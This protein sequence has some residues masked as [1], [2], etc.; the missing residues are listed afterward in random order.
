[1]GKILS[2][3]FVWHM[4]QPLYKDHLTGEYLMPWV[5]LHALKDYLD[6]VLILKNYPRIR[7][8]FNLVPSLIDQLEDYGF[9]NAHD[10]HSLLMTKHASEFSEED[11][12]FILERFFDANYNNMIAANGY[13]HSLYLKAKAL[14]ASSNIHYFSNKEY[15]DIIMWFNLVWFDPM[16]IEEIPELQSFYQQ[17]R[18]FSFE[19]K[20]KLLEIQR[21]I[22]RKILPTYKEYQD[23]GQIEITTTPY[24]HPIMPLL[25]DTNCAKVARPNM[26]LPKERFCHPED[27]KEQLFKAV[28]KYRKVF[29][30]TP[31]GLWPSE[32]SVS[33]E[34]IKY[35]V[36]AGIKW[37]ISDEGV[38][39]ATLGTDFP[40]N[41]YGNLEN[42]KTL[43]QPYKVCIDDK[44]IDMVF[45]NIVYSDLIGFQ[46]GKM[47]P[48]QAAWELYDR[49]KD[50]QQ[51][52][53]NSTDNHLVT[54]ALDGENCWEYY[55]NDGIPF[56]NKLYQFLSD[57]QKLDITTVS[58]YLD[59]NTPSKILKHIHSG[60][61]INR[62][63]HIW[64]GDPAKNTGWAYLKNTRDDLVKFTQ[65]NNY[66][67]K[68]IEK[69]WEELYIA[70]GSD[71]FWWYGDP[72]VSAQDDLFDEQFRL[73]LQNVY[74][75]LEKPIPAYLLVPVEVFLGRSL[76]YPSSA[77][78]PVINGED[79][80]PDEWRQAGCI[81]LSPGTMY[82]SDK[83]LRR[84]WFG[85]DDKNLH[86]RLD[87]TQSVRKNNYGIYIYAYNPYR[88]RAT[89]SVRLRTSS[90]HLPSTFRYKYAYEIALNIQD[91]HIESSLSEA[92]PDNL[93]EVKSHTNT[94]AA[95]GSVAEL[96]IPFDELQV[97]KN[98]DIHFVVAI[99]KS[100]ILQEIAPEDN[101]ISVKRV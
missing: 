53:I 33:P 41:F 97:P 37:T 5:R 36:E 13:Y 72:N 81:E 4:H 16:W 70:E 26:N 42:P 44:C 76:K 40:R 8:T 35:I 59:K 45:R 18:N 2:V 64:I 9:N 25:I 27:V 38:L 39:A 87:T 17:E 32:Q 30:T 6:M 46:F 54:I 20:I 91:N 58:E 89:S 80:R 29:G 57:D 82:Q 11:K 23:K 31:K 49:I 62:D 55:Q 3:A 12:I 1:M 65:N 63:F 98:N 19:Q 83:I 10:K 66:D 56:L 15:D 61:W 75:L 100:Q 85:Y 74:R 47:D 88:A 21:N 99:G 48:T 50:I 78:T 52:L 101:I 22:I 14:G 73:H 90:M 24:Y 94:K 68:T 43:S 77:F 84:I 34:T 51:K 28:E 79:D 60:S 86:I 67:K 93:W 96:S 95:V 71:W 69:A 7:Q 92:I